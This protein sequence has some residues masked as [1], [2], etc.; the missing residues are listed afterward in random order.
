MYEGVV[1]H[2]TTLLT[3]SF[4]DNAKSYEAE[5]LFFSFLIQIGLMSQ[6]LILDKPTSYEQKKRNKCI[7]ELQDLA[8]F[9]PK[10]CRR[11]ENIIT[12]DLKRILP[13][14]C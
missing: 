7:A 1:P 8:G 10:R 12:N 3:S 5:G 9:Q 14:S 13:N 11:K 6:W 4:I 2:D